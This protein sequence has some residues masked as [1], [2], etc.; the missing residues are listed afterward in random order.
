[1]AGDASRR[2]VYVA[3]YDGDDADGDG[4]PFTGADD[5]LLWVEVEIE[6][7]SVAVA[8]LTSR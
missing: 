3:G 6:N 7:T 1:M 8:C 2:L 5:G 4:D